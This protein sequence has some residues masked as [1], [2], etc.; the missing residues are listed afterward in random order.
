VK[1]EENA[2]TTKQ[3]GDERGRLGDGRVER[4]GPGKIIES[5]KLDGVHPVLEKRA[6]TQWNGEI[7][8]NR[9]WGRGSGGKVAFE[10]GRDRGEACTGP[11][12]RKFGR[13]RERRA[14]GIGE[15]VIG[16]SEGVGQASRA[17]K[18]KSD[19]DVLEMRSLHFVSGAKNGSPLP[20]G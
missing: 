16:K 18:G 14:E 8:E 10:G 1:A 17:K 11:L 6:R 7:C 9:S 5:L 3:P 20:G 19:D 2:A 13:K 4:H 15:G 12:S